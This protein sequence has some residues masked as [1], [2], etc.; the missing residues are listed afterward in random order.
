M[1]D[2]DVVTYST[3][4]IALADHGKAKKAL[5]LFSK[6]QEEGIKPNQACFTG[7]LNACGHA[8]MIEQG[9][10][11]F[12]VMEKVFGIEPLKEHYACMVDLLGRAGEVEMAYSLVKDKVREIDAKIWGSLL[13]ACKIHG[14]VELG[15]IAARYLF[16]M[17]PENTGNYVLLA[18]TYAQRKEWDEAEKIRNMMFDRGIRKLPG[19]SW[20]SRST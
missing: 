11:Y 6:M 7:V 3:M 13:G 17:E 5:D 15:E 14:N 1:K 8:G 20:I 12:D 16:E 10:K 2:K 19:F 4:I 9:C 18:N